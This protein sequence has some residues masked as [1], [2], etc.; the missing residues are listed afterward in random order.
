MDKTNPSPETD[1]QPPETDHQPPETDHQPSETGHQP[2]ETV[3]ARIIIRGIVQG[4]Y[5]RVS[6]R[7]IARKYSVYGWV[8]NN[9]DSSVEAVFE[10]RREDV[11]SALAWCKEGPPGARVDET[12]VSWTGKIENFKS[13]HVDYESS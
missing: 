13:F 4:V 6:T 12:H 9:K 1:H 10:G 3:T 11:E 7:N 2:S 5:F 8:R